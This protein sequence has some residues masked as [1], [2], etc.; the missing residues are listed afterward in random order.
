MMQQPRDITKVSSVV[1]AGGRP[2]G[3]MASTGRYN[4]VMVSWVIKQIVLLDTNFFVISCTY[5]HSHGNVRVTLLPQ[6]LL[7][8]TDLPGE[9][10]EAAILSG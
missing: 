3:T 1:T 4:G 6:S 9:N 2:D 5:L 8:A 10:H 7:T